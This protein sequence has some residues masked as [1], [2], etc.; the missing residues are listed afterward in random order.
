MLLNDKSLIFQSFTMFKLQQGQLL[1]KA[2]KNKTLP[3]L[4]R[5]KPDEIKWDISLAS[6]L[7]SVY[8]IVLHFEA[9]QKMSVHVQTMYYLVYFYAMY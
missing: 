9:K 8:M 6:Q 2:C 5:G 4:T 1:K 7:D 3:N